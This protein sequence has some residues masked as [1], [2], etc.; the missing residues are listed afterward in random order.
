MQ[1]VCSHEQTFFKQLEKHFLSKNPLIQFKEMAEAWNWNVVE[2][3]SGHD[4]MLVLPEEVA[5]L[6][7]EVK[8]N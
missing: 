4:V 2:L 7:M 1:G 5:G 3:N 6:V 8:S